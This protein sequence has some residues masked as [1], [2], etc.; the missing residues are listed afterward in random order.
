[1]AVTLCLTLTGCA[2][3]PADDRPVTPPEGHFDA[4]VPSEKPTAKLLPPSRPVSIEIPRIGAKSTLVPVGLNGDGTLEV[5]PVTQPMQAAWYERS[6]TP[7]ERG[8]SVL[9]GHVDGGGEP[10]IFHQL[11][12][13]KPGDKVL[14]E[15]QDGRTAE[16]VVRRVEQVAKDA[17]PTA[18][19]YGDTARAEVRLIT[20]GGSFDQAS[21]NYRDNV[22]AYGTLRAA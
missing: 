22:I 8:P 14:V 17:F 7:G 12:A 19:V 9:L 18:K 16:F 10:G 21:G 11:R 6:P 1:M 2:G 3:G 13:L 15:R 20:C 5:P 4:E